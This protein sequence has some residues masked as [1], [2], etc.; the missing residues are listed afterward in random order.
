MARNGNNGMGGWIAG[1][2]GLFVMFWVIARG[3]KL[4]SK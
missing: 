2:L 3:W 4:G 1:L